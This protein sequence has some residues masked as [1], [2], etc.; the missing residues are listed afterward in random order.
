VTLGRFIAGY[1]IWI[2]AI[3]LTLFVRFLYLLCIPIYMGITGF[4]ASRL[5]KSDPLNKY[6]QSFWPL[7]QIR[8]PKPPRWSDVS[9]PRI[10][11]NARAITGERRYAGSANETPVVQEILPPLEGDRP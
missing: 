8:W 1:L 2:F 4:G 7:W 6:S 5:S 11:R 10:R 3:I 9:K